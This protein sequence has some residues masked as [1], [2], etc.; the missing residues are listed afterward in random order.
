MA[1]TAAERKAA[2]RERLA[3]S[4]TRK[5]ELLVDAQELQML[6]QNCALRRPGREPYDM[7]EYLTLLIRKD[8]AELVAQVKQMSSQCC[9]KCGDILPVKECVCDGDSQCWLTKGWHETRLVI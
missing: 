8:N 1:K 7:V 5:F 3:E 9:G 4:G 6:E 2:Q